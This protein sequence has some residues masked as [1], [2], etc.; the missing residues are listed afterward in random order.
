MVTIV[1]LLFI[2]YFLY[3]FFTFVSSIHGMRVNEKNNPVC[4]RLLV[5]IQLSF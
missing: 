5:E 4:F 2:L 1:G 3:L